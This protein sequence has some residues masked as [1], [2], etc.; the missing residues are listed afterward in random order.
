MLLKLVQDMRENAVLGKRQGK[1][2]TKDRLGTMRLFKKKS[3]TTI[4]YGTYLQ[5]NSEQH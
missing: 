5:I 3:L 2:V 4:F 1:M